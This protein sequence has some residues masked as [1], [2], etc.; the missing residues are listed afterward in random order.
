MGVLLIAW[1]I[2]ITHAMTTLEESALRVA[3]KKSL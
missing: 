1:L 2:Q 3:S